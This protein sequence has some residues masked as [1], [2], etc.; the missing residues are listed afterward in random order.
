MVNKLTIL[1]EDNDLLVLD[2]PAGI[3]THP[4]PGEADETLSEQVA[5]YLHTDVEN[6]GINLVVHRLDKGTSG[7]IVFAKNQ[8][9]RENLQQ[10]FANRKTQKEYLVLVS[11]STPD[12][13]GEIDIPLARNQTTRG[14]FD[15][16]VD[17]K[18]AVTEFE[19]M[20][21]YRDFT[22]LL[23]RPRTGRTHQI[24]THFSAI[25]YPVAG[26]QRYGYKGTPMAR[27]FLHATRLT[28]SSPS[29]GKPL[30]FESPLPTELDDLLSTLD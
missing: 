18:S 3:S 25:G 11:G 1:Y 6:G 12:N 14:R 28:L 13:H 27:I 7:V 22:Y 15:P 20:R 4:A 5:A 19:V 17:G 2:K 10:Q 21:R 29:S 24:R 8:T 30:I 23:A 16:T 9:A 26:D